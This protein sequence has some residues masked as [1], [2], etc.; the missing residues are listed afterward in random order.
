[1]TD[2]P[3]LHS[4]L[5]SFLSDRHD[6]HR[7]QLGL[8]D[9]GDDDRWGGRRE[10]GGRRPEYDRGTDGAR[11]RDGATQDV[12]PARYAGDDGLPTQSQRFPGDGNVG[13]PRPGGWTGTDAGRGESSLAQRLAD[14]GMPPRPGDNLLGRNAGAASP[15]TYSEGIA[16]AL[17]RQLQELPPE[18]IRQ[19]GHLLETESARLQRLPASQEAMAELVA[20]SLQEI[21]DARQPA[22][23]DGRPLAAGD[24]DASRWI[25][26]Q[27]ADGSTA[28]QSQ[29]L[30]AMQARA[31]IAHPA[32]MQQAQLQSRAD[33]MPVAAGNPL[34]TAP[35]T[36]EQGVS[37]A[38]GARTIGDP[39]HPLPAR[40]EGNVVA[41]RGG[42]AGLPGSTVGVAAGV[43]L[44]AVGN[45]AGT[46][47]AIAPQTPSRLRQ[48]SDS[49]EGDDAGADNPE[50]SP[51]EQQQDRDGKPQGHG[52]AGAR[53]KG[54]PEEAHAAGLTAQLPGSRTPGEGPG[55]WLASLFGSLPGQQ[56]VQGHTGEGPRQVREAAQRESQRLRW[57]YW[58]LIGV[59]YVCLAVSLA[60]LAPGL[61]KLP[62]SPENLPL[63]RNG[64]TVTGLLAGLWAWMLARRMR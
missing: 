46:T 2:F 60:T 4:A 10:E 44:A 47:Y 13:D 8:H 49:K 42:P 55:A 56:Q 38:P 18:A 14:A 59:A 17:L 40:A 48:P 15:S 28:L 27:K 36:G 32:M 6:A 54:T 20:R 43:T 11:Y 58:T 61:S 16:P 64:M 7:H 41:D 50:A 23:A 12:D 52:E 30:A 53:R 62:I 25:G 51:D 29:Q 9:D 5:R 31:E 34:A 45:P 33:A 22:G 35:A 3:S 19:L 63:W 1:M 26:A 21:R 39:S 24:G 37:L 57:L